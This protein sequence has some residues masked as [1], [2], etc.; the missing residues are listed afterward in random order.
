MD[1]LV[2]YYRDASGKEP[3]AEFIDALSNEIQAK[4]FRTMKLL[5]DYGVL[6]KEPYTRQVRGKIRELRIRDSGGAVRIFYFTFTG[7]RII[8]LHGFIKKTERTPLREIGIAEKR[9]NDFIDR[10]RGQL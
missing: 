7:K 2:E 3:V 10:Q 1:W 8:L 9:M 4:V 5:K 6:L